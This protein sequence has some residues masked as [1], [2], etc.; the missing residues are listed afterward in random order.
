MA[1]VDARRPEHR[2]QAGGPRTDPER[3]GACGQHPAAHPRN[4]VR[5]RRV[6]WSRPHAHRTRSPPHSAHDPRAS[7]R[8]TASWKP[9][10][11]WKT[12]QYR[13]RSARPRGVAGTPLRSNGATRLARL[14]PAPGTLHST[15]P[16]QDLL[17][18]RAGTTQ[19]DYQNT[20]RRIPTNRSKLA[21]MGAKGAKGVDQLTSQIQQVRF[22]TRLAGFRK[23]HL[24]E[25]ALPVPEP[26]SRHVL[27]RTSAFPSCC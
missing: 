2:L 6:D 15:L 18:R 20:M 17:A 25:V 9:C 22:D 19:R 10:D 26:S 23:P 21:G 14:G 12:W 4:L 7:V 24:T 1:H 16:T 11:T 13:S 3:N 8:A 27:S 5:S